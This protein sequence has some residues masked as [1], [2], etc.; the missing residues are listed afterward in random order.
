VWREK[1]ANGRTVAVA[2]AVRRTSSALSPWILAGFNY[3]YINV[4]RELLRADCALRP[5]SRPRFLLHR[6]GAHS[7]L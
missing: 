3:L 5:A 7:L 2:D 6:R 1:P 4:L